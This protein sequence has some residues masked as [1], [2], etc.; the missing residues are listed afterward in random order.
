L[1]GDRR[2]HHRSPTSAKKPAGQDPEAQPAL[3]TEH[4]TALSS[5]KSQFFLD[6]LIAG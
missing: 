5:R 6:N 4:S 3:Q 1:C 2:R